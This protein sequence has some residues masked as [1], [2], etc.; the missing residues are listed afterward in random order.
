[1][2]DADR[3]VALLQ[4]VRG[5]LDESGLSHAVSSQWIGDNVGIIYDMMLNGY[6]A[7]AVVKLAVMMIN[8]KGGEPVH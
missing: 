2:N 3:L 1:M 8:D 7:E 6:T 4:R 5:L